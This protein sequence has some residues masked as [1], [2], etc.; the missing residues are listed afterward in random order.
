MIKIKLTQANSEH[1]QDK[2]M[3]SHNMS[4]TYR[5]ITKIDEQKEPLDQMKKEIQSSFEVNQLIN[6]NLIPL[7]QC[8][9]LTFNAH[10]SYELM[11]LQ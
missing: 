6:N 9:L 4:R 11:K 8:I 7:Y 3:M 1:K 10:P 5:L 2:T